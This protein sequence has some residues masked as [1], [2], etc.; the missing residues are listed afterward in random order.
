VRGAA[1]DNEERNLMTTS[2]SPEPSTLSAEDVASTGREPLAVGG[3]G[4]VL[5]SETPPQPRTDLWATYS[6]EDNKL[7][8]SSRGRLDTEIY[9]RVKAAGFIWA[10]KQDVFVAPM[11]TPGRED[12]LLELCG[13]IGDEDTS[14][15]ERAEQRA[16][17]FDTYSENRA[18]DAEAAKRAVSAIADNIPLGQPI[19][20]GHHSERKARRDAERIRT[21]MHKAVRLWDTSQYWER[22]AAACL[23]HAQ[24]KERPEVRHRR[25]KTL[26]AD[27]RR[28]ARRIEESERFTKLWQREGLTLRD[29]LT[30]ANYDRGASLWSQL[31]DRKITVE[32][33]AAAALAQHAATLA[34]ARRWLDHL[35]HRLAYERAL[36]GEAGGIA[37]ERFNIEVGGKVLIGREWLFVQRVTRKD[38]RI[39]SVT[40][41]GSYRRSIEKVQDY[42]PPAPGIAERVKT[43]TKLPP[44]CNYP[45]EGFVVTTKAEWNR[46]WKQIQRAEA[47]DEFGA[48]RYRVAGAGAGNHGPVSLTDVK[49]TWGKNAQVYL[50]DVKRTDRPRRAEPTQT[51]S[52]ALPAPE[53]AAR[54]RKTSRRQQPDPAVEAMR[55]QLRRG[56]QVVS[57]PQLFITPAPLAA[58]MV[59]LA[60]LEP[61][62]TVLEPSAGTGALVQAIRAAGTAVA[63]T[64]VE[65]NGELVE[66][67][68][69]QGVNVRRGDFL[70][71]ADGLGQ[72]DRV[73]MN[74]P[75]AGGQDIQHIVRAFELL[76]PGGRLVGICADGPRQTKALHPLTLRCSGL[77]RPLPARIFAGTDVRA[78]LLTLTK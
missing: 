10:P 53:P 16:E 72:F 56:V 4:D 59:E 46:H 25:I 68:S 42:Q 70:E 14:L 37:A 22:R 13:E 49:Y 76:R 55:D 60:E 21:G 24:Y 47:T 77:W 29:A 63:M 51:G 61:D 48:Y 18:A 32:A 52:T 20:V 31:A 74:P 57:A 44:L 7:R 71:L 12:L 23:Q 17:R 8:L 43:A 38:G 9:Q 66:R 62:N 34:H 45:G 2:L 58:E 1:A 67:L 28:Q 5:R 65:I 41:L 11:W 33:A 19:L 50:T 69:L 73:V 39:V 27:L 26:E 54:P 30:I 35:T 78:V 75:F 6:P 15:V 36:L 40:P 64:A 3:D